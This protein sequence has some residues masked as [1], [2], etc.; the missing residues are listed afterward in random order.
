MIVRDN[1]DTIRPCLESIRPWVDEI[2][3][4]DTGSTDDTP[5]IV[6]SY[7]AKLGYFDWIDDFS[8]ARNV[9]IDQASGDW[10]FWMDSDDTISPECGKRLRALADSNHEDNTLGYVMQVH[11]P[12]RTD[13]GKQEFTVVDHVKMFRNRDDLRF[14]GRIHEQ[15]LMN[16][17]RLGGEVVWTDI[18]VEHSGSDG[19]LESQ[20]KKNERDLRILRKDLSERPNHP[21]VLFNF[22]MTHAEI[23]EFEEALTWV[24]KCLDVSQPEES[25]VRK[26]LAYQV[27][28]LF[29]LNRIDEALL[30][31]QQARVL[32]PNDVE[33]L[34]R[35]AILLHS[36]GRNPESIERYRSILEQEPD[37]GFRSTD[38]GIQGFKCRFNLGLVYQDDHQLD[39]AELQFRLVLSEVPSY[40]PAIQAIS[41]VL[42]ASGRLVTA[43]VE[44]EAMLKN[45][46]TRQAGLLLLAQVLEQ[47]DK[48]VEAAVAFEE[49]HKKYPDSVFVL[50]ECC[51]FH[52]L[53]E[54]WN[55]SKEYL[56]AL[57]K[58]DPN[59]PASLH[60]LG[61][62]L[63]NSG[64]AEQAVPMLSKS[65]ELR[66][67]SEM[68]KELLATALSNQQMGPH[69]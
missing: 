35:E 68:T 6:K 69:V 19:S 64:E 44:A 30:A 49:C 39:Q 10:I 29:Q 15:V 25:H 42:L 33:L 24:N 16:I 65:L 55:N 28:C 4:V 60:N 23:G 18:H 48:Q 56:A 27:N 41:S 20:R 58:L 9:S 59:N 14:E 1:Q 53:R 2:I 40:Q 32:Y 5:E 57:I 62:A 7:G 54:D 46:T 8:A 22:A 52:F 63:L 26:T 66:P 21:F 67:N 50:E 51:R 37:D 34:F 11:C 43:E 61:L 13:N 31:S 45:E 47:R 12:S 3:V 17:R 38:P 36:V